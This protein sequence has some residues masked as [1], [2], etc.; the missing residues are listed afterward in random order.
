M[1][2]SI[3]Q[4]MT[5][6]SVSSRD[7]VLSWQKDALVGDPESINVE[8]ANIIMRTTSESTTD[9]MND[10]ADDHRLDSRSSSS[11]DNRPR[12]KESITFAGTGADDGEDDEDDDDDLFECLK[13]RSFQAE[14]AM[15][16]L[17]DS[18]GTPLT[19]GHLAPIW[20]ASAWVPFDDLPILY[21]R[22][23]EKELFTPETRKKIR[24]HL[25][26]LPN[27]SERP[28]Y[29]NNRE[30][31]LLFM[32]GS[33]LENPKAYRRV[34]VR[35]MIAE[36][37]L[38]FFLTTSVYW[39]LEDKQAD[40]I[41]KMWED[42]FRHSPV[43]LTTVKRSDGSEEK[44]WLDMNTLWHSAIN[45]LKELVHAVKRQGCKYLL[46][47]LSNWG[48]TENVPVSTSKHKLADTVPRDPEADLVYGLGRDELLGVLRMAPV[49]LKNKLPKA[50]ILSLEDEL[51]QPM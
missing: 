7:K 18:A 14:R 28:S 15:S 5:K 23:Y 32:K 43:G 24:L 17:V 9:D 39:P 29:N 22:Y 49:L 31:T 47:K 30:C 27:I 33:H 11:T 50:D 48:D 19:T 41:F 42:Q 10:I 2:R 4:I 8:N 46:N 3:S 34:F 25:P 35:Q 51:A 40:I 1:P 44:K 20:K 21:K 36:P 45:W 12:V 26:K 38:F 13:S 37:A 16:M 6:D